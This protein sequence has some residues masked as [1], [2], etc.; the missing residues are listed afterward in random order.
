MYILWKIF[1][2]NTEILYFYNEF[3]KFRPPSSQS[4]WERPWLKLTGWGKGWK[5]SSLQAYASHQHVLHMPLAIVLVKYWKVVPKKSLNNCQ[6]KKL[7][8]VVPWIYRLQKHEWTYVRQNEKYCQSPRLTNISHFY[9]K[10]NAGFDIST[11]EQVFR[12]IAINAEGKIHFLTRHRA[13]RCC[14]GDACVPHKPSEDVRL[15]MDQEASRKYF[16]GLQVITK[17]V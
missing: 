13:W 3:Y 1:H 17:M 5:Q 10:L 15:E 7:K 11:F 12:P 4:C 8:K 6:K 14:S 16:W 9:V 2:F